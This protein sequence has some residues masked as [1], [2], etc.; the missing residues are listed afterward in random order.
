MSALNGDVCS[1]GLSDMTVAA[2]ELLPMSAPHRYHCYPAKSGKKACFTGA[3]SHPATAR[4]S[5]G[6]VSGF[7]LFM[8]RGIN[9]KGRWAVFEGRGGLLVRKTF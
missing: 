6:S 7:A 2:R 8:K 3:D 9:P 1:R 5:S 4:K